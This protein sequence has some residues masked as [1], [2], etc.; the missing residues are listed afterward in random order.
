MD[1]TLAAALRAYYLRGLTWNEA[2]LVARCPGTTVALRK[3]A[4]RALTR[5][6]QLSA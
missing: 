5:L 6:R 1:P 3:A 2:A 4:A